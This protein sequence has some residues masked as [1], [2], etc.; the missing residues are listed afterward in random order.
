MRPAALIAIALAVIGIATVGIVVLQR[1]GERGVLHE[2]LQGRFGQPVRRFSDTEARHAGSLIESSWRR[3]LL[4]RAQAAPHQRF[5]NLSASALRAR[6]QDAARREGFDVVDVDLLR[7]RQ[8][9]PRIVVQ[10]D[11][12]LVM[13]Q[14]MPRLLR[15]LDPK[16][17]TNDD[18]TGWRYEGFYFEARD[19][20]GVPFAIVDNFWRGS[21]PG[22]G[23]WARSERLFPFPHG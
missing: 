11:D 3:E 8:L 15:R 7:P 22:G 18:R 10:T 19:K 14:A 4:R 6:L 12:Y 21:G 1:G 9:A 20:Q 2:G 23:Q 13:T 5:D 16:V 17:R